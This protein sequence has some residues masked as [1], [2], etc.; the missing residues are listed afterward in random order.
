MND[1]ITAAV[2]FGPAALVGAVGG[3]GYLRQRP[4][5]RAR[6]RVLAES[7][8]ARA[9]GPNDD[10][11]PPDGGQPAPAEQEPAPAVRLAPVIPLPT[12]SVRPATPARRA[13]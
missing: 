3:T 10:P 8:A 2:L 11:T 4:R 12:R 7:R 5:E 1:L 9:A 13:A 6:A